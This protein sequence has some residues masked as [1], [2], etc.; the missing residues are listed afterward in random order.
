[1]TKVKEQRDTRFN[2]ENHPKRIEKTTGLSQQELDYVKS[3]VTTPNDS[4]QEDERM[5]S[6]G[7]PNGDI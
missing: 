3:R 2:V 4:L 7:N 5:M 6:K 1:L